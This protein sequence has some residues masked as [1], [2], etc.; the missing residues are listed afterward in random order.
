VRMCQS[1]IDID[2]RVEH[3]RELLRSTSDRAEVERIKRVIGGL[4][5]DRARLHQ[6]P[7]D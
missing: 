3:L 4:F 6:D 2:K 5:A 7:K 1:C